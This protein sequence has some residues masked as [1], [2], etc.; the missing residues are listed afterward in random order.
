MT[1]N[2]VR[3]S[4]P[5]FCSGLETQDFNHRA[6]V[7]RTMVQKKLLLMGVDQ[8]IPCLIDRFIAEG[9]MPNLAG[10]IQRGAKGTGVSC[11][12]PDTPTNWATIATGANVERHGA[13]SF[14]LHLPGEPFETGLQKEN[15][16]RSQLSRFA[17]AEYLWEVADESGLR[18]F[19]LN[20]PAGW[21]KEFRNGIMSLFTWEVPESLPRVVAQPT[22][23]TITLEE[24][25]EGFR[26]MNGLAAHLVPDEE[27]SAFRLEIPEAAQSLGQDEWSKW[28]EIEESTDERTLPCLFKVKLEDCSED[29]Q[30]SI[31]YSTIYNTTGWSIPDSFGEELVRNVMEPEFIIGRHED[32]E[33]WYEGAT[34]DYLIEAEQEARLMAKAI[35]HARENH[36]WDLCIF[37]IHFLDGVNHKELAYVY[38]ES[39]QYSDESAKK[40]LANIRKAYRLI[41]D[42]LGSLMESVVDDDTV[43]A[44]VSDHGAMPAW[45]I[46]NVP[47]ALVD[48]DLL[49]YKNDREGVLKVDWTETKAFP[50][51]EPPYVWVNK[52]G[53]DP[54]GIVTQDQFEEVRQ[55]IIDTLE[56]LEDPETG[57]RMVRIALRREEAAFLGQNGERIGDVI[58]ALNPPYQI[59]DGDAGHLD[60][61]RIAKELL[62]GPIAVPATECFGAH[63]YYLP[64]SHCG[65]YSVTV[66]VVLAGPGI[67]EGIE[68]EQSFNLV[69]I[70]PTLAHLLDIRRPKDVQG[71]IL[72][73]IL[74]DFQG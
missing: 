27:D 10:L 16:S 56:S 57:K 71:R 66:P 2:D 72:H 59:F 44:F 9:I 37:H 67:R 26:L 41:D 33:Y 20:Y 60:A 29:R 46:A 70:A 19:V 43:V 21:A 42:L 23:K 17:L 61:S 65:P 50:Y 5:D 31:R 6:R 32:V 58:F 1:F 11:F 24:A 49:V 28:L 18:P 39:P 73:E 62:E 22:T 69:D 4:F 35:K 3:D 13:T 52:K 12:P 15:R 53:R 74:E 40:A 64:T 38:E 47:K 25:K 51:L 55:K 68:L 30:T 54:E 14:Y 8:A 45:K 63:A 7:E 34:S 36:G 48:A